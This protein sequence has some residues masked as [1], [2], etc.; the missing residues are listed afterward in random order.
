MLNIVLIT[1]MPIHAYARAFNAGLI[2]FAVAERCSIEN[3][4]SLSRLSF[5]SNLADIGQFYFSQE[6]HVR[7]AVTRGA[8]KILTLNL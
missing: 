8:P 6:H 7:E 2:F 4:Y 3:S 5:Y 1:L